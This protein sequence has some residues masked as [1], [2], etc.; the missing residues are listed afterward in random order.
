MDRPSV[1]RYLYKVYDGYVLKCQ[2]IAFNFCS[3]VSSEI[4]NKSS[5]DTHSLHIS[6]RSL[7]GH[8]SKHYTPKVNRDH[9]KILLV[10]WYLYKKRFLYLPHLLNYTL[11]PILWQNPTYSGLPGG[12]I[13]LQYQDIKYP[14]TETVNVQW[15]D[16]KENLHILFNEMFISFTFFNA[17]MNCCINFE[18]CISISFSMPQSLFFM[19][20]HFCWCLQLHRCIFY[21]RSIMRIIETRNAEVIE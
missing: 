6:V 16:W 10:I 20:I 1:A 8:T 4:P 12:N 13:S 21:L 17:A 14:V 9:C 7:W 15:S 18:T 11:T 3:G 5:M 2:V 19:P